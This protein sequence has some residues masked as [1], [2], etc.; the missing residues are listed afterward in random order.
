[1][2]LPYYVSICAAAC[3]ALGASLVQAQQATLRAG[4]TI[5]VRL[6][7]VPSEEIAGFSAVQTVDEDGMLNIPYIGKIKVA[8]LDTSMA[9]HTIESRLISDKIYTSPT[10]TLSVQNTMR[11]VNVTGEVK[12]SGR[13]QYTADL[14][15][16]AAIAGA[17]GFSDFADRRH[18]KLVRG[19]KVQV[20][21]T[22]KLSKDPSLDLKVVPGDQIFVPQAGVFW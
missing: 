18:V 10:V 5:E 20:I 11:L 17:G 6:A 9:Q 16:M 1:M 8:G 19:G 14:T 22:A 4:D 7:G 12:S 21:D 13:L 15:V 3:L 2:R